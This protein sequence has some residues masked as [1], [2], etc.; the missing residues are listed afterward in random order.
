MRGCYFYGFH[1]SLKVKNIK[2]KFKGRKIERDEKLSQFKDIIIKI[3][4]S[5]L[6]LSPGFSSNKDSDLMYLFNQRNNPMKD[7]AVL[8]QSLISRSLLY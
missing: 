2:I 5:P 7:T 6:M 8:L 3:S 4:T 1:F